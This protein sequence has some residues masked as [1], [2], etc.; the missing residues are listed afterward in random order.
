MIEWA[1]SGWLP[2]HLHFAPEPLVEWIEVARDGVREPFFSQTVARAHSTS[3]SD[4]TRLSSVA[5]LF[6]VAG[7]L[8]AVVP[9]GLVFHISRCGSSVLANA[10]RTVT[11]MTVISEAQP[12]HSVLTMAEGESAGTRK[13]LLRC[14]ARIYTRHTLGEQLIIKFTSLDMLEADLIRAIWPDTPA[15]ILIRDPVEVM[16]SC[17]ASPPGW[18]RYK[19]WAASCGRLEG[20]DIEGM[21]EEEYCARAIGLFCQAAVDMLDRNCVV[22][23]Y[24][25]LDET[26]VVALGRHLTL[27][28]LKNGDAV[29]KQVLQAYSKDPDQK[30]RYQ[31]DR[32][33]KRRAATH[34]MRVAAEQWACPS[35][36]SI[37]E[38]A[39]R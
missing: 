19:D 14:L 24:D 4:H 16:V 31:D 34:A 25:C 17:L 3:V 28:L 29:L 2:T 5:A 22:V 6:G 13:A 36:A 20:L 8:E 1:F 23:D 35:Y 37:R 11:G 30:L 39:W 10:F 18:L 32:E 12:F 38:H 33:R 7:R 9:T 26:R 21:S 27:D 15:I